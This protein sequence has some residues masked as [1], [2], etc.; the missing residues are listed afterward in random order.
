MESV[1]RS[2]LVLI[3]KKSGN[4]DRQNEKYESDLGVGRGH[5]G[6]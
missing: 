2:E 1:E 3:E 4:Q 6:T 5:L